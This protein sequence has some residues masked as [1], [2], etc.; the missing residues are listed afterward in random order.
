MASR[1]LTPANQITILRLVF[2]PI[3]AILV[4]G[5]HDAGALVVLAAAAASDVL[6]GIVARTFRQV[7]PLGVALDPIADKVMMSTAFITLSYRGALPWWLTIMVLSRDAAILILALLIIL[8]AGYRPFP[9]TILGKTSTVI[10]VITV[11]A[12]LSLLAHMPW[13]T[14]VIV[15][16]SISLAA[17]ITVVSGL[18]YLMVVRNRYA[19]HAEEEN[20][21][22][23][24][25]DA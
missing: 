6:D 10:Q 4:V 18:H 22:S 7:T 9:P 24:S 25:K 17:G 1:T 13:V 21:P 11:F 5:H 12:A 19:Q 15:R 14:P 3:F 20:R 16:V 8:V 23:D 2:V